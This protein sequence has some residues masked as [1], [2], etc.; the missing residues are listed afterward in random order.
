V[1]LLDLPSTSPPVHLPFPIFCFIFF[2]RFRYLGGARA[3]LPYSLSRPGSP[4]TRTPVPKTALRPVQPP[5]S[6]RPPLPLP[7][8]GSF[9]CPAASPRARFAVVCTIRPG[10]GRLAGRL[11]RSH[12][13]GSG[14]YTSSRCNTF[15][16]PPAPAPHLPVEPRPLRT[17]RFR[18]LHTPRTIREPFRRRTHRLSP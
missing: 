18:H 15:P 1:R 8:D 4:H 2:R 9:A 13:R 11:L 6:R 5:R 7:R 10:L 3:F 16:H 14:L 12:V 17:R